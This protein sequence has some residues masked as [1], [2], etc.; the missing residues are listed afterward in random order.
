MR[1]RGFTLNEMLIALVIIGIITAATI[2]MFTLRKK[3]KDFEITSVTC[4]QTELAADL[5][6]TACAAAVNKAKYGQEKAINTL[7]FLVNNGQTGDIKNAASKI[8]KQACDN[9]GDKACN[10]FVTACQRDSALCDTTGTDDGYDLRHYLELMPSTNDSPKFLIYDQAKAL[11][12][13]SNA[14][15]KTIVDYVCCPNINMA[16]AIKGVTSC[17]FALQYGGTDIQGGQPNDEAN[18]I[19][20]SGKYAYVAGYEASDGEW[21]NHEFHLVMKIRITDGKVVWKKK[22]GRWGDDVLYGIALS[23]S[24]I[25]VTGHTSEGSWPNRTAVVFKL[26]QTDGSTVWQKQYGSIDSHFTYGNKIAVSGNYVYV[27]GSSTEDAQGTFESGI[28]MMKLNASDGTIVWANQYAGN[29]LGH[30]SDWAEGVDSMTIANGFI[31]A[32]GHSNFGGDCT[33]FYIMKMNI[34]DGSVVYKKAYGGGYADGIAVSGSYIYI[35][36]NAYALGGLAMKV[37]ESDASLVWKKMYGLGSGWGT[38]FNSMVLAPDG[39]MYVSG[40]DNVASG[41]GDDDIIVLKISPSDGSVVWANQ[42]G[43]QYE[44]YATS[45]AIL[46]NYLYVAGNSR[47]QSAGDDFN[48]VVIKLDKSQNSSNITDWPNMGSDFTFWGHNGE[49]IPTAASG[50]QMPGDLAHGEPI[51][52]WIENGTTLGESWY[53]DCNNDPI[54]NW[55]Y[56]GTTID[57]EII[58][59]GAS[60]WTVGLKKNGVPI[61]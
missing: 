46:D 16:C 34:S 3:S 20:V 35:A 19:A 50:W 32:A 21:G 48:V 15:I 61:N 44:E 36:G 53:D 26:N 45:I 13:S 54:A 17:P 51:A 38:G 60:G 41:G 22:W 56:E 18:A 58:P 30:I 25:Y 57:T 24:H 14:N 10:Y 47:F 49:D 27:G 11:Y 59:S 55:T 31:Y 23:G 37:N 4:A 28:L 52:N 6:S 2:P 40:G 5:N 1:K 42:F 12:D 8:L 39:Y 9:G 43:G 33:A 7:A 29:D